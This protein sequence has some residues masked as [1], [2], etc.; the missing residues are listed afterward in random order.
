M[1]VFNK[2]DEY[3]IEEKLKFIK[4]DTKV[5]NQND[6]IVTDGEADILVL[7]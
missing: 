5:Y 1:F 2:L 4:C 3:I 7:N 6:E